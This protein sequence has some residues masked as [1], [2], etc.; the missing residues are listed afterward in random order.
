M[1][2][3]ANPAIGAGDDETGKSQTRD[4]VR[5]DL[6]LVQINTAITSLTISGDVN[7]QVHSPTKAE[8]ESSDPAETDRPKAAEQPGLS[9]DRL[10]LGLTAPSKALIPGA[11]LLMKNAQ[12]KLGDKVLTLVDGKIFERVD[13]KDRALSDS[14]DIATLSA[15][16][17][18]CL[19]GQKASIEIG[20][21]VAYL[22]PM[23]DDCLKLVMSED[24]L[25]GLSIHMVVD[26]ADATRVSFKD[27]RIKM[28]TVVERAAIPG[29]P[30]DV[31]RPIVRSTETSSSFSLE[32]GSM[33]L[34]TLPVLT[35]QNSLLFVLV[36]ATPVRLP[37]D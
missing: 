14:K 11:T 18:I 7:L 19:V 17:L 27:L 20:A 2:G 13:G 31:G 36:K 35:E 26:K 24:L 8:P 30:F 12:F 37:E 22:V 34:I 3:L 32:P 23:E 6:R 33:A 21:Q 5:I 1:V 10:D 9:A 29:V 16:S 15:P 4:A 25:E 28:S